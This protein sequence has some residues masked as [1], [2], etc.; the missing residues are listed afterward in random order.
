MWPIFI[1]C[2]ACT[3]AVVALLSLP[4]LSSQP[5]GFLSYQRD[6][7][8]EL[9]QLVKDK[10]DRIASLSAVNHEFAQRQQELGDKIQAL[11]LENLKLKED[12]MAGSYTEF[13]SKVVRA[14]GGKHSVNIA[15]GEE[16]LARAFDVLSR[17]SAG[18]MLKL[19]AGGIDRAEKR[20]GHK[21]KKQ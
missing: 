1:V 5:S 16:I 18:D 13:V 15:D 20:H 19:L 2:G 14:E 21:R 10:D 9:E 11:E 3:L 8:G 12:D 17:L 7:I 6:R 4:R